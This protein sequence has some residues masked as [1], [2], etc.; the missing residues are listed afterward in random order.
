MMT[1]VQSGFNDR[2]L[3][4]FVQRRRITKSCHAYRPVTGLNAPR[5]PRA[6]PLRTLLQRLSRHRDHIV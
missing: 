3:I 2:F 6:P 5:A 1:G 4:A